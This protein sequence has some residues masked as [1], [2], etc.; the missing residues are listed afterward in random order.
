MAFI[1]VGYENSTAIRLYY[2]DHG[3]G[4]FGGWNESA[5][6]MKSAASASIRA[7]LD[8]SRSPAAGFTAA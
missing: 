1:N 2:E 3:T 5:T 7:P 6:M 4:R 8:Q